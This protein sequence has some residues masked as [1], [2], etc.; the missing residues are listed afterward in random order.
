MSHD[1]PRDT[2]G[3]LSLL[4]FGF[5]L[6][7]VFF[8]SIFLGQRLCAAQVDEGRGFYG[9]GGGLMTPS[10]F[11]PLSLGG[12]SPSTNVAVLPTDVTSATTASIPRLHQGAW[13]IGS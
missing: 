9:E 4:V 5:C 11:T 1:A 8:S 12:A 6:R 7:F 3:Y 13:S 2:L 10:A